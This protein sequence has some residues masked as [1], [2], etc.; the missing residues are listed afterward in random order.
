MSHEPLA[1]ATPASRST[2]LQRLR[3]RDVRQSSSDTAEETQPIL[4]SVVDWL[5]R[6]IGAGM[7][8]AVLYM[9]R[10][11]LLASEGEIARSREDLQAAVERGY[12]DD[13]GVAG[14]RVDACLAPLRSE[15]ASREG[16]EARV[17]DTCA[18]R[19]RFAPCSTRA[20]DGHVIRS[21]C[22]RPPIR[23]KVA[24]Q[25]PLTPRFSQ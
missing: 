9:A 14:L 16:L 19:Q 23:C 2:L 18:I 7:R 11:R 12:T 4:R 24:A 10:A 8:G 1:E 15:P 13:P 3:E 21:A 6:F 5:D 22:C 25:P 20:T 17:S